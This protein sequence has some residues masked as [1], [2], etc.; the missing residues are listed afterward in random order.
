MFI[1]VS[2]K[3]YFLRHK[4][5]IGKAIQSEICLFGGVCKKNKLLD[6]SETQTKE[7]LRISV[8]QCKPL[9]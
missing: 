8:Q 5:T 1:S 2:Q 4:K 3:V 9:S 7:G 6:G